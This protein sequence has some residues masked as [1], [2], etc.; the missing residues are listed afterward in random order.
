MKLKNTLKGTKM[1]NNVFV[2]LFLERNTFRKK[3][4]QQKEKARELALNAVHAPYRVT[5]DI[6]ILLFFF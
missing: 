2:I 1:I 4:Q 5:S 3:S 6:L